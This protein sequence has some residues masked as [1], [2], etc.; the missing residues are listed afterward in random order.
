VQAKAA[1]GVSLAQM[2][3]ITNN[4]TITCLSSTVSSSWKAIND[5]DFSVSSS[6]LFT[7]GLKNYDPNSIAIINNGDSKNESRV[8]LQFYLFNLA[9]NISMGDLAF[10]VLPLFAKFSIRLFGWQWA[11]PT[12]HIELHMKIT[13][14]FVNFTH[15]ANT[16]KDGMTTFVFGH[17]PMN[18]N[19]S[20]DNTKTQLQLINSIKLNSKQ[21]HNRVT[22]NLNA[23]RS[24]LVL[25]FA[26]FNSTLKYNP[27]M[28]PVHSC[29]PS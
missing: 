13:P 14:L 10:D 16:P 26:Y 9:T 20:Q 5:L 21:V 22:F 23:S 2:K 3:E 28:V 1:V 4:R 12:D 7:A 8:E 11:S 17:L 19:S 15:Q 25:H 29:L 24:E 6:Y 27:G 18:Q